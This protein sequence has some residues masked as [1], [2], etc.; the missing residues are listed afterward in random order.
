MERFIVFQTVTLQRA[1]HVTAYR[2]IGRRIEK[3]LDAW[4]VGRYG[5]LVEDTLRS[6]TQYLTAVRREETAEH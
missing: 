6:S 3:R 1:R 2:D 4:E 5:T